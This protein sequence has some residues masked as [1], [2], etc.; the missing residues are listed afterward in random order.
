MNKIYPSVTTLGRR[1]SIHPDTDG[2][3]K[4]TFFFVFGEAQNHFRD[5]ILR[6]VLFHITTFSHIRD[7]YEK[8][9]KDVINKVHI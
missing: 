8:L 5:K 2:I 1:K 6:I 3:P 7:I 4:I 9:K